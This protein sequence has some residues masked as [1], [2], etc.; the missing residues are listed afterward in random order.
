MP[1]EEFVISGQTARTK[2]EVLN[3]GS[4]HGYG[5]KL[6]EFRLYPSTGIGS[7][8]DELTGTI[9]AGKTAVDPTNPD[10]DNE[11][12]IGV[13]YASQY[14]SPAYPPG[15]RSIVND[16]FII[17]QNLILKVENT[18]SGNPVNWQCRFK[19]IKLTD[20]EQANANLR[21]F[22]VFDE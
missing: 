11:G 2:T 6:I 19:P 10:F 15:D 12:L 9:T 1:T 3:F 18:D 7:N 8:N 5:F 21:Q 20:T 16:T 14:S 22:H 17:T 4:K 13:A